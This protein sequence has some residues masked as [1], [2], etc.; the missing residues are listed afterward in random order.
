MLYPNT[1]VKSFYLHDTRRG[2][3]DEIIEGEQGRVM[4]GVLSRASF[5]RLTSERPEVL[6]CVVLHISNINA[7][8]K[9]IAKKLILRLF[10]PS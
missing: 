10:V 9:G 1:D 7:K 8:K 2:L 4:Q 5:R 6:Y 3:P